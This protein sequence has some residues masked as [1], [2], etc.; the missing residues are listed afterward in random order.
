M[1]EKIKN[2]K[3]YKK[4]FC[5][6]IKIALEEIDYCTINDKIDVS[7]KYL[8]NKIKQEGGIKK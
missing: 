4:G 2:N 7:S 8:K 1:G 3:A 5:E 6:A